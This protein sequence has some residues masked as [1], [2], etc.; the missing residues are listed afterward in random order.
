MHR[1]S[2]N[3]RCYR[4]RHPREDDIQRGSD[5][6]GLGNKA[7]VLTKPCLADSFYHGVDDLPRLTIDVGAG[8]VD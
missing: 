2:R 3:G 5:F 7:D 1:A 6:D 4:G 8:P